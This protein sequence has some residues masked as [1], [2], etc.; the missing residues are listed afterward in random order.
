VIALS[1]APLVQSVAENQMMFQLNVLGTRMR[2]GLMAAIFRKCLVLSNTALQVGWG[3]W[4]GGG[5]STDMGRR[6]EVLLQVY[7]STKVCLHTAET[8]PG[9][10]SAGII[11]LHLV[12]LLAQPLHWGSAVAYPWSSGWTG[13]GLM[14]GLEY[15]DIGLQLMYMEQ[16]PDTLCNGSCSQESMPSNNLLS[17][18][19][20]PLLRP[21]LRRPNRVSPRARW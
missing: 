4:V 14:R 11:V 10:Q 9:A 18:A 13:A 20:L 21:L 3:G 16:A 1:L 15:M 6:V 8:L 2:N 7:R 12:F 5:R 19:P 17:A